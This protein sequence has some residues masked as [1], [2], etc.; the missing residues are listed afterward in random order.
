VHA[1]GLAVHVAQ[2]ESMDDETNQ[3]VDGHVVDTIWFH[4]SRYRSGLRSSTLR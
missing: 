4:C 3:A 2:L 1:E